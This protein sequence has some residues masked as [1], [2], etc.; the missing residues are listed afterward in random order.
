MGADIVVAELDPATA[1]RSASEVSGLGRR[2]LV[3]PT[4]VTSHKDLRAMVEQT[5]SEFG[6][7]DTL[8]NN[9][10][11]YRAAETL[12]VTEEH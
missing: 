5:R 11:I 8:V 4:D 6:R 10:G 2:A 12:D 7:I 3:A 1:E 9:A